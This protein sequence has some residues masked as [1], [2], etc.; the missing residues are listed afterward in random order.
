MSLYATTAS[1][2]KLP[3][4]VTAVPGVNLGSIRVTWVAPLDTGGVPITGYYIQYRIRSSASY[5]I[6]LSQPHPT[7]ATISGLRLGTTYQV[8]L[9]A[10]TAIGIGPYCCTQNGSQVF[11]RTRDG[12]LIILCAVT[13][14]GTS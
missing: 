3:I 4:A 9:A 11:A 8:R 12:K 13:K 7:E 2:S 1:G 5:D 10:L 6:Q 14:Y